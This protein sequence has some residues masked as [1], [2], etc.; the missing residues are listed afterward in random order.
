MHQDLL[1]KISIL[2]NHHDPLDQFCPCV[3]YLWTKMFNFVNSSQCPCITLLWT[4]FQFCPFITILLTTFVHASRCSERVLDDRRNRR[5]D[6]APPNGIHHDLTS[7][8]TVVPAQDTCFVHRRIFPERTWCCTHKSPTAKCQTSPN[9][10]RWTIPI[11]AVASDLIPTWPHKQKWFKIDCSPTPSVAALTTAANSDSPLLKAR[12]LVVLDHSFTN[13]PLHIA[14]L[15][16][17]D[18]L[19]EWHPAKFAS[20]NTSKLLSNWIHGY[21]QVIREYLIVY[22][23]TLVRA[24]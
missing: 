17:V 10:S 23:A 15:P 18:F 14:T 3:T 7:S 1:D 12:T 5:L 6:K 2:F 20:P 13:W 24:W 21:L 22:R 19:V 8:A 11:A 9:P 4:N 16:A